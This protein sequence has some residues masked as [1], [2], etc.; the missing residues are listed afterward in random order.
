MAEIKS[1]EDKPLPGIEYSEIIIHDEN[2][3]GTGTFTTAIEKKALAKINPII[4]TIIN[5]PEFKMIV[6]INSGEEEV[7]V[8]LG[9]APNTPALSRKVF[10]IPEDTKIHESH[11]FR[12]IFSGW[13]IT[14][15]EL[16][17]NALQPA[18]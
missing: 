8:L 7:T 6:T 12:V 3:L 10:K 13:E 5:E 1:R 2:D 14:S 15:M 18:G 11:D 9:K 17:G 16:D 4:S